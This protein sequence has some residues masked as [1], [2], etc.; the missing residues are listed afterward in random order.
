LKGELAE[1][2]GALREE[3][4]DKG[5]KEA[6]RIVS[7]SR[8]EAAKIVGEARREADRI[9]EEAKGK[10]SATMTNLDQQMSL[11]LRD[12]LLKARD[13]L[14]EL[15]ALRPLR[16]ATDKALSDPEFLKKLIFEIISTYVK[17]RTAK[18]IKEELHIVIPEEMKGQFVK[19]W[20]AMMRS[21]LE[22]HAT[23]H[24]ERGFKG[25]KLFTEAGGG[26][27]VVDTDSMLEVMRPFVSERFRR[28]LD[29]GAVELK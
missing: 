8:S 2:V 29:E 22:T 11:A 3:G 28:I 7:D 4:V 12:T 18:G 21:E 24:A 5:K 9:I 26:E 23:L 20:V 17:S 19:E 14:T 16:K 25:F 1:L 27:L 10:A 6:E 13:E 15:V